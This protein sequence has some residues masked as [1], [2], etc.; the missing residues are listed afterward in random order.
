VPDPFLEAG[1]HRL[2]IAGVDIDDPVGGETDLGQGR[3]EQVLPRDA[4]EHLAPG[5]RSDPSREQGCCGSVDRG[6]AAACNFVQRAERQSATGKAAVD[7]RH[8]ERQDRAGAKRR[9]LKPLNLLAKAADGG[10]LDGSTHTLKTWQ[11]Y[12]CS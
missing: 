12:F 9:S 5:P 6:I 1:Q 2:L 10:R 7:H 8:S 11:E 3:H 4:P